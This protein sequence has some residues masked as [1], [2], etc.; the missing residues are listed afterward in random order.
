MYNFISTVGSFVMAVGVLFFFFNVLRTHAWQRGRRAGND[1]WLAQHAR[2][3]HDLAAAAAQL[4][5][6]PVRE[7]ARPLRDL[8]VKLKERA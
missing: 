8:R 7:S 3:A 6:R 4:R 2:V 5:Q 1:P